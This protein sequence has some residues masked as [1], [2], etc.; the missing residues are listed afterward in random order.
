MDTR[1]ADLEKL[2]DEK[3][4]LFV[5]FLTRQNTTESLSEIDTNLPILKR[6]KGIIADYRRKRTLARIDAAET[7]SKSS[8]GSKYSKTSGSILVRRE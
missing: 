7:L 4:E 3:H 1:V 8:V 5:R 2:Y 6:C